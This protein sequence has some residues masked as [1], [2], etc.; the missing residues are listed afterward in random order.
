[1]SF[2]EGN[3]MVGLLFKFHDPKMGSIFAKTNFEVPN[4]FERRYV[5]NFDGKE[6]TC[7]TSLF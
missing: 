6:R 7:V 2:M 3:Q 5:S 4:F 1:M